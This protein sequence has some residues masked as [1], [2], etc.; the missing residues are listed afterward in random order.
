MIVKRNGTRKKIVHEFWVRC[1]RLTSWINK[2]VQDA[3]ALSRN[4]II[5]MSTVKFCLIMKNELQV[6]V[7][8]VGAENRKKNLK[9]ICRNNL[10]VDIKHS[11]DILC[12]FIVSHSG[13]FESCVTFE[14]R[15]KNWDIWASRWS[16]KLF[17]KKK[18]LKAERKL[19]IASW[20]TNEN[21]PTPPL[22]REEK[23]EFQ[24]FSSEL[25]PSFFT[26]QVKNFSY[27]LP[28]TLFVV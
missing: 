19:F 8:G 21:P 14:L 4:E 27:V 20:H 3:A 11:Q 15:K 12:L 22:I 5:Q 28:T 1:S 25:P 23:L 13:G 16:G 6:H 10:C 2:D 17:L 24:S 9:Q 18:L 26:R 7:R